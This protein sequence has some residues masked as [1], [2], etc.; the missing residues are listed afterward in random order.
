M[1][2]QAR[3]KRV[4]FAST[5]SAWSRV[6]LSDVAVRG[7]GHTPNKKRSAYWGGPVAWVSLKDTFRLDDGLISTTTETITTSGLAHSSAVIHP[8]GSVILLRDAGI[9]KSAILATD[10]AVSQHFMAWACGPSL[11]NWYLY[12]VLQQQK[13][14]FERIA[15]GSTI[16]TIGLDYFRQLTIP[17]PGIHEQKRIAQALRAIDEFI[18][19][20]E[21]LITKKQA[22]KQ[23]MM[24][25]LLTGKVRLSGFTSGGWRTRPLQDG[26]SLI[27]GTHVMARYCNTQGIGT[28][29]LTGPADF[30][31]GQ[32][33][34][35]K[36]TTRPTVL[37]RTG[38]IL[39]TVKGS[40][41]GS[42]VI[43]DA[44][45]CISRQL[46]AVRSSEWDSRFLFYSLLHN[47]SQIRAAS[48]G[49][50]PG[51][52]RSDILDQQLPI[53]PTMAEQGAIAVT[54]STIDRQIESL[55]CL[56]ARKEA[57]KMG[58]MQQLLTGKTRLPVEE[59]A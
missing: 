36:F 37:C 51:L 19:T 58:M 49:L 6:R 31:D 25:Q 23:G 55:K 48:A 38:D 47:A 10:M 40:G 44:E 43:S 41:S 7:S 27:S 28:P 11:D 21:R 16:K 9:G 50:I 24:Q 52:S 15:N 46:M 59:A 30:P 32:I 57:I 56:S 13:P 42:M 12:Y 5:Q 35:T 8:K 3:G 29:Y 53:P 22:I 54:L 18:A 2:V 34:Q 14:E 39:I 17:L 20:L 1:D 33:R 26:V 4:E 45:Y